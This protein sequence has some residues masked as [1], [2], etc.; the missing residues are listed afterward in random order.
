MLKGAPKARSTSNIVYRNNQTYGDGL[1]YIG[2][3]NKIYGLEYV[4]SLNKWQV[5]YDYTYTSDLVAPS[6]YI[7]VVNRNLLF[8]I[9][10]SDNKVC[11]YWRNSTGSGFNV[12]NNFALPARP[13]SNLVVKHNVIYYIASNSK[14]AYLTYDYLNHVWV[15]SNLNSDIIAEGSKIQVHPDN[16]QIY[17]V[18]ASDNKV[19]NYWNNG[20]QDGF[21]ICDRQSIP[22]ITGSDIYI[23]S[24]GDQVIYIGVDGNFHD[25]F[26]DD[27]K[28]VDNVLNNK[29]NAVPSYNSFAMV[30]DG[31]INY[32]DGEN[33]CL[34]YRQ[35]AL[36]DFIYRKGAKLQKNGSRFNALMADYCPVIYR[37]NGKLFIGPSSHYDDA[38]NDWVCLTS[39]D[40]DSVLDAHFQNIARVGFNTIRFNNLTVFCNN[41][42]SVPNVDPNLYVEIWDI[43]D[44]YAASGYLPSHPTKVPVISVE[45]ELFNCFN[46][47]VEKAA[48]Y[49]LK[50]NF[51]IGLGQ[52]HKNFNTICHNNYGL[53]LKRLANNFKCNSNIFM[54]SILLEPD[55]YLNSQEMI[56]DKDYICSTVNGWYNQIRSVDTNHLISIG[57]TG[58]LAIEQWDPGILN[59][60]VMTMH[61]Y[62][63]LKNQTYI[64]YNYESFYRDLKWV[65]NIMHNTIRKPWIVGETGMIGVPDPSL[66]PT[67]SG[68]A[69][70]LVVDY[71]EQR[72]YG[73]MSLKN[74]FLAGASGYGWWQYKDVYTDTVADYGIYFGLVDHEG[75]NKPIIAVDS[76]VFNTTN[77]LNQCNSSCAPDDYY[78]N[79]NNSHYGYSLKGALKD[80]FGKPVRDACIYFMGH[81]G[82]NYEIYSTYSDSNGEF[83]LRSEVAISNVKILGV[84]KYVLNKENPI[85][86]QT[87]TLFDIACLSKKKDTRESNFTTKSNV[88]SENVSVIPNPVHDML[89]VSLKNQIVNNSTIEIFNVLGKSVFRKDFFMLEHTELDVSNL[90]NGVYFVTIKSK[91]FQVVNKIIKQ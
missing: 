38:Y 50:T 64:D 86:N 4:N 66:F 81:H 8:Y 53:Y 7:E 74:V 61:I 17:Y 20:S 44:D 43:P 48:V 57:I 12:L 67:P 3:N 29:C 1:F 22:V 40:C 35:P 9:R 63:D 37:R 39:P 16:F 6:S 75:D 18:R 65:S 80:E 25:L 82:N 71:Q 84:G 33:I 51:F 36:S 5:S 90:S 28:Y 79:K 77:I 52:G 32:F 47:L 88:K 73:I 26:W 91:D 14:L 87:Y 85:Q 34:L 55:S 10:S 41:T 69:F 83:L 13:N 15:P 70:N 2:E 19:C 58:P 24:T 42:D 30:N 59:V 78:N 54:Y 11:V 21:D 31:Q 46:Q 62:P 89:T 56:L 49:N 72:E 27:C 68:G 60:D 23:P 76:S 45:N